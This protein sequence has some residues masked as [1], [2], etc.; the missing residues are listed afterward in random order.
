M[1]ITFAAPFILP[2]PHRDPIT[3][4]QDSLSVC[5]LAISRPLK[6]SLIVLMRDAQRRGVGLVSLHGATLDDHVHDV[7]ATC[8]AT[9]DVESLVVVEVKEHPSRDAVD[10][11]RRART[12]CDRAGL[13][14]CEVVVVERGSIRLRED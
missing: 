4:L 12:A 9:L 6:T 1:S 7:I 13:L 5:A 3:T 11:L 2:R 10:G 8:S 14:L